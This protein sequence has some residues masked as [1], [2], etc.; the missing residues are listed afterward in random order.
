MQTKS[1]RLATI[2]DDAS[3][4]DVLMVPMMSSA[5]DVLQPEWLVS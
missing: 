4:E 5:V 1:C 2:S 3:H